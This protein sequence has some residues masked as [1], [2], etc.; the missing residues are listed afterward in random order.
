VCSVWISEQT[1]IISIY[2]TKFLNFINEMDRVYC[3]VRA[4]PL[5]IIQVLFVFT[6]LIFNVIKLQ[7]NKYH[8]NS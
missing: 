6:G 7:D 3:A 1:A 8:V 4:E 5:T 2:N